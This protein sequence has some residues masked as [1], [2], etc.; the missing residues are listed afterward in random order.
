MDKRKPLKEYYFRETCNP[1]KS[2]DGSITYTLRCL[3]DKDETP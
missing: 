3:K 1:I 2:D